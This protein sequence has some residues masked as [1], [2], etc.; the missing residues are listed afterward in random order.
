[1]SAYANTLML[2]GRIGLSLIFVISGIRQLGTIDA[3]AAHMA[4]DGMPLSNILVWGAVV[5]DL[6]VGLLLVVG[7]FTRC[8]ALALCLYTLALAMIF[9]RFWTMTGQAY[10][11][12]RND[13]IQHFAI[14]G[15]ML[16]V[17]AFGAGAY[18]LDAVWRGK[19]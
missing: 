12:E 7:L 1:M 6:G 8:A 16:Y 10:G 3:T 13:F 11:K 9:H 18:S 4:S 19:T 2:L 15:G 5:M 17:V 14:M